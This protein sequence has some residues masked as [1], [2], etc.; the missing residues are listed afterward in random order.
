MT[1]NGAIKQLHDLGCAEDIPIYYKPII[2]GVIN[3][4]R[5]DVQEVKHGRWVNDNG[6]YKC[7][8]CNTFTITGWA[9]CIPIDYM[10]KTMRYCP[11]CGARM[12]LE[13][14]ENHE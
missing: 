6:L 10:N 7:S 2:A 8:V 5:M 13:E 4:L 14:G 3:L 12:D 11:H 1:L 9:N